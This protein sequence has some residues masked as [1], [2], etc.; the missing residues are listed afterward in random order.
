M[1]EPLDSQLTI[2]KALLE[3][4]RTKRQKRVA[5][6]LS[7]TSCFLL[8]VALSGPMS[9]L[10]RTVKFKPLQT[11]IEVAFA[12]LVWVAKNK[13]EPLSSWLLAYMELFR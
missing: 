11:A 8:Y 2:D 7:A 13:I 10:H 6:L 1:T 3:P 9:A 4:P 5:L 12:P